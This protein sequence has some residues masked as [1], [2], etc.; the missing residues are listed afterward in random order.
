MAPYERHVKARHGTAR[1][2]LFTAVIMIPYGM[3]CFVQS[4]HRTLPVPACLSRIRSQRRT[5][6]DTF[7]AM[8]THH[9][10]QLEHNSQSNV[11]KASKR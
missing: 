11:S 8:C 2:G 9:T 1:H 6:A 10:T 4:V 7:K 3:V 5:D